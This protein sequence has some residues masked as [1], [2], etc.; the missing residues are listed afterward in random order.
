MRKLKQEVQ[1]LAWGHMGAD[2]VPVLH[3]SWLM[4]QEA[5]K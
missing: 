3:S 4:Q 1:E 5:F 2:L